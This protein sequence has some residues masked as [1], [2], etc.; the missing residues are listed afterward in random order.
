M[1][2]SKVSLE[3]WQ[4]LLSVVD[5]GGYAAA[6]EALGK[7]QSTLSYAISRLEEQLQIRVF[8][9]KGRKAVLTPAGRALYQ[10]AHRLLTEA[11]LMEELAHSYSEN[12]PISI[13]VA[14][15]SL[16]PH[17][18]WITALEQLQQ[19]YPK[20]RVELYETVLSGTYEAILKR[21]AD[22]VISGHVPPA[23]SGTPLLTVHM[24]AVARAD[25]PLHNSLTP[26]E[27]HHL[28]RHRQ[29]VIRDS[30][31]QSIDAGWLQAQQRI[32]V[33]HM[34][35]AIHLV[36]RGFGFAWLPEHCITTELASGELKVLNMTAGQC[37]AIPLFI[38]KTG[39]GYELPVV[40]TLER[41]LLKKLHFNSPQ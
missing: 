24:L 9:I 35:S 11:Q 40:K 22:I 2:T 29:I 19:Q 26:L 38:V 16:F 7:S 31:S 15:D 34:H 6:A 8:T 17:E 5:Q 13:S 32:T 20:L 12:Q 3:Q 30:G 36:K 25:H 14:I 18:R 10:R 28:S 33:T 1:F 4:T 21:Q 23:M 37:M 39:D 41:Y 27:D